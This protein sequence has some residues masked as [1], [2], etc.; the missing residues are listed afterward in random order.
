MSKGFIW[1]EETENQSN[2]FKT[3]VKETKFGG[4]VLKVNS[5]D[6]PVTR[7]VLQILKM[8][9]IFCRLSSLFPE[10]KTDSLHQHFLFLLSYFQFN[11][12]LRVPEI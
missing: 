8:K 5:Q 12:Q 4:C 6:F 11:L 3:K 7:F 1:K 10:L 9:V 2:T